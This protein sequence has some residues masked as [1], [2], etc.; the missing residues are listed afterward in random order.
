M[1]KE[2][3][4]RMIEGILR[5]FSV[6]IAKVEG[7]EN[8]NDISIHAKVEEITF[9]GELAEVS[10]ILEEPYFGRLELLSQVMSSKISE[11]NLSGGMIVAIKINEKDIVWFE[12]GEV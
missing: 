5:L 10:L 7:K 2:H 4:G 9:A 3:D 8:K 12:S 1:K 11:L 6:Q